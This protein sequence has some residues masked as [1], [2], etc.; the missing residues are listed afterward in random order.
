[1][2]FLKQHLDQLVKEGHL[3]CYLS[4][5]QKQHLT[6]EPRT[7]YNTKPPI[8]VIEMIHTLQSSGQS[9]N[10]LRSDLR[11]AQHLQEVFHVAEGSIIY[12]KIQKRSLGQR[13]PDILL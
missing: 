8:R 4:D 1:M 3:C 2:F 5:G 13:T 11:K 7:A 6:G 9:H 12:K 10:Q